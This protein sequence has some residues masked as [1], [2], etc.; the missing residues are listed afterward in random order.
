MRIKF[1]KRSRTLAIGFLFAAATTMAQTFEVVHSFGPGDGTDPQAGITQLGD[2]DFVG[3]TVGGLGTL[4][5][6]DSRGR[7]GTLY[8][9]KNF[10]G[11]NPHAPLALTADGAMYGTTLNGMAGW[12]GV[13]K[14]DRSGSLS[15][16]KTF[17]PSTK[18]SEGEGAAP[19]AP[20]L[21]V[22]GS[23]S[24]EMFYGVT[25]RGGLDDLGTIFSMNAFGGFRTLRHF[26]GFDG[27]LPFESLIELGG[28]LY[29]TTTEGGATNAGTI[30][31]I[32]IG[33][34][35]FS[36]IHHFMLAD[37]VRPE[38]PLIVRN[39]VLYG[40]T[41]A[42]GRNGV[43]TVFRLDSSGAN[44]SVIHHFSGFDGA[45]P[46]AALVKARDGYL[47]GT[48]SESGGGNAVQTFGN[49]FRMN[50]TGRD[51][52]V[53]HRFH[54]GDGASSQSR[55]IEA[56]DGA[57][58]GTTSRGGSE[59][60]GVVFRLVFVP[61]DS[62]DP[63]SGPASGGTEFVVQGDNFQPGLGLTFDGAEARDIEV[64]T[65][66]MI[67]G[68]TPALEPGTLTDVLV[69]NL[70]RTRGGILKGFF[71]DFLDVPQ[72]DIFHAFVEKAVRNR[73]TA[74][75]GSGLFGRDASATR[76]Q[77]AVFLLKAKYGPFYMPPA[78]TGTVFD[79]VPADDRFAAWIEQLFREG[80]SGGCDGGTLYCPNER[81][82]REQMAVVLL[83]TKHGPDF[84]PPACKGIFR[85]VPCVSPYAP[86]IEQLYSEGITAGCDGGYN[87]CPADSASRGQS[88]VFL[89]RTFNLP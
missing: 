80:I 3:T 53:V 67:L 77:M 20:L 83:K 45:A 49:I 8:L 66:S 5:K 78:A 24:G 41:S 85:D 70:D 6:L 55:L 17:I 22:S 71:A 57:L 40:T 84:A 7:L 63:A 73:M 51:F 44:F 26:S 19:H 10:D 42:G 38:A 34:S 81:M 68:S 50:W 62:I 25:T 60:F 46:H 1:H 39:G 36:V 69:D 18:G 87:F 32:G 29:G 30:F 59:D 23:T 27:A 15:V 88:A 72:K 43:G 65:T 28:Y 76:A 4:F 33:G 35:D 13:F 58:Y 48:T 79:D 14:L 75:I 9:F 47:Y 61:V 11:A 54:G 31:R 12:G 82:T 37:G 74:G 16:V 21:F 2:G 64:K 86:W 56:T 52:S 89:A